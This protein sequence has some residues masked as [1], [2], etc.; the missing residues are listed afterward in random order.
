MAQ[1]MKKYLIVTKPGI[2]CGNLISVAGGFFLASKGRIDVSLLVLILGGMSLVIA[3]GC[4]LNNW[5]DR[6]VDRKMDRTKNRVL[7]T[8]IMSPGAAVFYGSL[9]GFA[10]IA[11]LWVA[12]N[13]LSVAIV[14]TGF[15]IYVAVYSLYL[16]RRSVYAALIGSL[17]G[18][19]PPLAGYCAVTD[20]F[21]LGALMLLLIFSLWQIPHSYAIAVLRWRDYAAAAIPVLP[22]KKGLPA[23]KKHIVVYILAFMG[24]AVTLTFVGYTGT[25]YLAVAAAMGLGWLCIALAGDRTSDDRAWAKRLFV[26]SVLTIMV[27][28]VMMSIDFTMPVPSSILLACS[29]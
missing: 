17:A 2:L 8:G 9:L 10:G 24:A 14:V 23:A 13:K 4:V 12:T 20:R 29:P 7:A 18:A 26:S 15:T 11:L 3:S 1:G 27:L 6:N 16:K 21:D 5:V 28:S 19:A 25:R 22:V